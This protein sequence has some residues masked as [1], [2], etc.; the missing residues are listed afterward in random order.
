VTNDGNYETSGNVFTITSA[1]TY[2]LSGKLEGQIVVAASDEDEVELV[3]NGASLTYGENSPIFVS[4]ASDVTIKAKKGTENYI[5]DTRAEQTTEDETQGGGAIYAKSDLKLAGQGTLYV[6]GSYNNGVHTT[7]DL[8]IKN[9]TLWATSPN[10]TI[11]GNDSVTITSG[12]ITSISE[13]GDA[14]K[15]SSTDLSSAGKQRGTVSISGGTVNLY[16]GCDGIDASYN[17]EISNGTDEDDPSVTTIPEITIKTNKY[18][19][20]SDSS[21]LGSYSG[22]ASTGYARP[23]GGGGQPGGGGGQPGGGGGQPGGGSSSEKAADSAKGIKAANT[24][25]IAGG[26]TDITAYDDGVHANYGTTFESGSK[27][28]GDVLVSGGTLNISCSDDGIHADRYLN[29]SGGTVNVSESYEALEGNQITVS[30]GHSAVYGS[31]DGMNASNGSSSAGLSAQIKVTGGYLFV[32]VPSSGDTDGVDSNGSYTQ[33]GGTVIACGPNNMNMA[34]IDADGYVSVTGGTLVGFGY[35]ASVS[36]S[37]TKTSKS[38]TYGSKAYTLSFNNGTVT[39]EK[40]LSYNY[41]GVVAYSALGTL[42]SI[43]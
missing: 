39:T 27:G 11:K 20:Y 3:F 17:V 31:N 37:L 25:S 19:S 32:C 7:K 16:A 22:T 6:T 8:K 35:A 30:G 9:L 33:T 21:V 1:G 40:L 29:I 12:S 34:A 41:S 18:S 5:T 28:V 24:I 43:A 23:G 10:N 14:I 38:G 2:T 42:N 36:S 13:A 15:T 26:V 4:C